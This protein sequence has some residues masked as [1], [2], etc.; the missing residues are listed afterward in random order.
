V[1]SNLRTLLAARG[2]PG[3]L[4]GPWPQPTLGV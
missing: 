1:I 3:D 2:A 4:A